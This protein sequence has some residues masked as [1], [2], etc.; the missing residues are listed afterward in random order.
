MEKQM[1]QALVSL[2]QKYQDIFAFGP[3]EMP[4]IDLAVIEHRLNGDS[5]HKLIMQRKRHIGAE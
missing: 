2:L 5:A 4:K 3:E 1:L